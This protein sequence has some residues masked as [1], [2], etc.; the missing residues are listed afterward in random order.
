MTDLSKYDGEWE[1]ATAPKPGELA[2]GQ[3][4]CVVHDAQLFTSRAGEDFFKLTFAVVEGDAKGM[5]C[6]KIYGIANDR[7]KLAWLKNDLSVLGLVLPKVSALPG[8]LENIKQR[9]C[10]LQSKQNGQYRNYYLSQAT[11]TADD[12]NAHL[13]W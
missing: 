8:M 1:E 12:V 13:P 3:Y 4:K 2:D 10:I 11:P 7:K 9:R 5:T 6:S